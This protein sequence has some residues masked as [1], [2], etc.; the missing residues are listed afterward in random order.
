MVWLNISL[1]YPSGEEGVILLVQMVFTFPRCP[2]MKGGGVST[3]WNG[4]L[5]LK[6]RNLYS[7]SA[8]EVQYSTVLPN[9]CI[10]S[11]G[12]YVDVLSLIFLGIVYMC[13]FYIYKLYV[14]VFG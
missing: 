9:I 4:R 14:H 7:P 8:T 12:T 5:L 10:M 6:C 3:L 13:P 11:L 2:D 1:A